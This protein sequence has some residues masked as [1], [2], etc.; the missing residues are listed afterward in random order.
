M[1]K[2]EKLE[3]LVEGFASAINKA[4]SPS[5]DVLG[6]GAA[7]EL[8]LAFTNLFGEGA[9]ISILIKAGDAE[10]YF[11]FRIDEEF[12]IQEEFILGEDFA[13][14][15]ATVVEAQMEQLK[16]DNHELFKAV[17]VTNEQRAAVAKSFAGAIKDCCE[18]FK[19][20]SL[21][22]D[23]RYLTLPECVQF[24][25]GAY[26]QIF[27]LAKVEDAQVVLEFKEDLENADMITY[28]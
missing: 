13:Y 1:S 23:P 26:G 15:P 16:V 24:I 27:I 17:V 2:T 12:V 6:G 14:V 21:A 20:L 9:D 22:D 28:S 18:P 11:G 3:N 25:S 19:A 8:T 4:C 7:R 10:Q 5:S